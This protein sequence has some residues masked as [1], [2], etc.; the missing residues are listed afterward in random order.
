MTIRTWSITGS[1]LLTQRP[2]SRGRFVDCQRASRCGSWSRVIAVLSPISKSWQGRW[3]YLDKRD[4]LHASRV[5][6][7]ERD[8]LF[9][10]A[11]LLMKQSLES[12]DFFAIVRRSPPTPGEGLSLDRS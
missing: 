9:T 6:L 4:R 8:M 1:G 10:G 5:N 3:S 11:P 7:V 2:S 12:G